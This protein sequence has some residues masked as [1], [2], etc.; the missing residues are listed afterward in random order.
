MKST[1]LSK[2]N[3]RVKWICQR[4]GREIDE[5]YIIEPETKDECLLLQSYGD[6]ELLVGEC[7]I[8]DF[9]GSEVEHELAEEELKE[10]ERWQQ[11]NVAKE[12]ERV[13]APK[14][15]YKIGLCEF[16]EEKTLVKYR[17]DHGGYLCTECYIHLYRNQ[18]PLGR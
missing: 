6:T 3:P 15:R 16:C 7:C 13:Y 12:L 2:D 17:E 14:G 11:I 4:C 9:G 1:F 10:Y 18:R 8:R 5:G